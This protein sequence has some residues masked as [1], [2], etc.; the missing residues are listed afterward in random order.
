MHATNT[1][2]WD[3]LRFRPSTLIRCESTFD[4]K[5]QR[6]SVAEGL[7]ASKCIVTISYYT[8]PQ[9]KR[10]YCG[11]EEYIKPFTFLFSSPRKQSDEAFFI[12]SDKT[13]R[14]RVRMR[15]FFTDYLSSLPLVY[16]STQQLL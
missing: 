11:F 7:S 8:F 14:L 10:H 9:T 15:T 3:I 6:I 16:S 2:A 13:F 1:R 4:E 12:R 5:A